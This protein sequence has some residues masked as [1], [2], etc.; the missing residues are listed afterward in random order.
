MLP[1]A[2]LFDQ[3]R[4]TPAPVAPAPTAEQRQVGG[5][6]PAVTPRRRIAGRRVQRT[7]RHVDVWSVFKL[8]IFYFACFTILWLLLVAVLYWVLSSAGLFDAIEKFGKAMVLWDNVNISLL[9]VEKWALLLAIAFLIIGSL[10]N[11]LIAFLYNFA[12]DKVGGVELTFV[13]KDV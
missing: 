6:R 3:R 11:A 4:A 10:I 12:A 2:A 5:R 8:S 1:D 13:E 7:I 9:Y